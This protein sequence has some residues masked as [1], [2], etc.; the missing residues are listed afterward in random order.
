M[1]SATIYVLAL[2]LSSITALT[3]LTRLIKPDIARMFFIVLFAG[4]SNTFHHPQSRIAPSATQWTALDSKPVV[5]VSQEAHVR[6]TSVYNRRKR[7]LMKLL[8]S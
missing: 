1:F 3:Q 6:P 7:R 8:A 4:A 5:R 2:L